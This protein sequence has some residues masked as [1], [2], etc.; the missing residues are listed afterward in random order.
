MKIA[1][2]GGVSSTAALIKKLRHY[3]WGDVHIFGYEPADS[4][5][6]SCSTELSSISLN[7]GFM[8]TPFVRVDECQVILEDFAPDWIFVVGLS[9]LIPA[10]MLSIPTIGCIGFHPTSLPVGRG[11]API[12]WLILEQKDGAATFFI[13]GEGVDDGPIL[14]QVPFSIEPEDDASSVEQKL[15]IAEACALDDLLPKLRNGQLNQRLQDHKLATYFGRRSHEDGWLNWNCSAQSLVRLIRASTAPYPGAYTFHAAVKLR[16]L[17]ANI[18]NNIV[19][20]GVVGRI[21]KCFTD[22]GFVVQCGEGHLHVVSWDTGKDWVPK[23]GQKLGFYTEL[24]VHLLQQ[25]VEK[26]EHQLASLETV[27]RSSFQP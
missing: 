3:E 15:L 4:F 13:L 25:R 8:Y 7:A 24:E 2:I 21:L 10:K 1:V 14:V 26:L 19:E 9:Q 22:G 23:V 11:R 18:A 27:F 6:V 16:I 17:K 5:L 12:A 20:T